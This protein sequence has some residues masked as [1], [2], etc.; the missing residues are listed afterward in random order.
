M[1]ESKKPTDRQQQRQVFDISADARANT[2]SSPA[3]PKSPP[4]PV[5]P[6]RKS[7][8]VVADWKH[9]LPEPEQPEPSLSQQV[10]INCK[11]ITIIG[12]HAAFKLH[13]AMNQPSLVA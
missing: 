2:I 8:W 12:P 6:K 1:A 3:G 5:T 10:S 11:A 9:R 7:P 4:Q 13:V